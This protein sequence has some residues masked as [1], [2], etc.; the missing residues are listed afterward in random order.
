MQFVGEDV[1]LGGGVGM[2]LRE[3]DDELRETFDTIIGELKADGTLNEMIAKWFGDEAQLY[4][5]D[6]M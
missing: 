5:L 2:G 4:D 1:A 3:G 6:D